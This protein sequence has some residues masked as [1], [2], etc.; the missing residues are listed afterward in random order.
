MSD[1]Q[2]KPH[3]YDASTCCHDHDHGHEHSHE[4]GN[5]CTCSASSGAAAE[6]DK[7]ARSRAASSIFKV[8]G[9]DCA[10][11]VAVL[12]R[13]IGPIVGGEQY[14]AFDV[15]NGRMSVL[16][17]A[18]T[19]SGE[20][21][22]RAV[23][24]TGMRA[25]EW[26]ADRG[27]DDATDNHRRLQ[28]W[29]TAASGGFLLFGLALHVWLAGGLMEAVRLFG[30]HDGH[31]MPWPETVAYG[32]AVVFGI[33]FVLPKA[34]FALRRLRPDM[35]LLMVIAI[36]G[37]IGIGELFEAATVAFLFALSL[38]LEGWSVGR[39]RR[40]ISA[41]LDLAPSTARVLD[42]SG[43]ERE[44]PVADVPEGARFVVYP[45]DR[46][47]LDGRVVKGTSS[48]NQA[49]ITGESVPVEKTVDSELFAGTIN[50][51]GALEA[52]S[53][54]R[55]EHTT[56]ACII[57]MVEEAHGRRA[58]VEHWVEKFAAVYTPVVIVLA[59][60]VAALPP[61]AF[62][63]P[64]IDCLYR[65]LVLLVIACPCAL[66]ISTPVSIVAALA[67]AARNGVLIKGGVFIEVPA[68]LKVLAMDKTGTITRGMPEVTDIMPLNGHTE[69]ELLSR[70]AALE[71]R[72]THPLA[73]AILACANTRNLTVPAADGVQLLKGKGITGD[74][75][76]ELFWLG[77]HRFLLECGLGDTLAQRHAESLESA[78]KTVVVIGNGEHVCGLIAVA[79]TVRPNAR[80]TIIRLHRVGIS[81]LVMLTGDN[82]VTANAIA[83][84]VGIDEVHAELLP[85]D[86]VS[87][88]GHL[89]DRYDAVAMLGD[90]VN[91]APAMARAS[92]GIA[93]GAAGSD[94]AIETAD[95][96]LMTDDLAKLPW[97]IQHSKRTMTII[98]QNIV[99]AL[100]VKAVFVF[101]TLIGFATLWGAIAADVGASLLV[102]FNGLRLLRP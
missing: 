89:A 64:W 72:S 84:E 62:G 101:L 54:K 5:V 78:G 77:S 95:I 75:Q 14:L 33:R 20:D 35:N 100:G 41:L 57:Q 96:A 60:A 21:I 38:T 48:V 10:E 98:R 55:A 2:M 80:E 88:I 11:E 67:A 22:R 27:A 17:G 102:V 70:A 34:W 39:A 12:K 65:A 7:L 43:S 76:G 13:E 91:D 93:M 97:L 26:R 66:V 85:E 8:Q 52:V 79:D 68:N 50:G 40:A 6:T 18:N 24:R 90:G 83:Q 73:R 29:L 9:L 19:V 42:Y 44:M 3:M 99:F 16:N 23:A 58:N 4:Q 25:E 47:A 82:K 61:L 74:F 36:A 59:I 46:I 92:L 37:A 71:A 32:L 81:H 15:L 53:T 86:K 45:G 30:G 56:L 63:T 51:D 87:E 28:A 1:A 31:G 49:P 94:A 69:G